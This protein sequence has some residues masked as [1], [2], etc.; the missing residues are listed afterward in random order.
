MIF[1]WKMTKQNY[2]PILNG[3]KRQD[4]A[5]CLPSHCFLCRLRFVFVFIAYLLLTFI[6][7]IISPQQLLYDEIGETPKSV[8]RK[9][10]LI[11]L[12]SHQL[13]SISSR[14]SILWNNRSLQTHLKFNPTK[15]CSNWMGKRRRRENSSAT[16][17]SAKK[18]RVYKITKRFLIWT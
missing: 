1:V 17:A 8:Y 11:F 10:L 5:D 9:K 2:S 15:L 3:P 4:I 7:Q 6:L 16:T 13:F 14:K 12:D 18:N